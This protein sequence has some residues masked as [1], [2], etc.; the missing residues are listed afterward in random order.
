[1]RGT[2]RFL[3]AG[4]KQQHPRVLNRC[5]FAC[6]AQKLAHPLYGMMTIQVRAVARG[7][8]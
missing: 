6:G 5:L 1:M 2:V 7:V 8:P 4:S 3:F